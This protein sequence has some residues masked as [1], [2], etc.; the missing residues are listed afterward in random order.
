[1]KKFL[2][3]SG[4]IAAVVAIIAFI[5]LLATNGAILKSGNSQWNYEGTLV[6]FGGER[7]RLFSSR[8]FQASVPGLIGWILVLSA[9]VILLLGVVLPLIKVKA[10]DKFAGLL[11]L[12]AV[13]ALIV[14]G[15]LVFFAAS[16][17]VSAN[18]LSKDTTLGVGWVFAGI[19]AIVAG[20][21]AILPAVFDFVGKKK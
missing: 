11:N 14:G 7:P 5:L 13:I 3:F 6:L 1:M 19:L 9:I 8:H 12:I 18:D 10:L 15:I 17:F 21:L 16:A 4:I 20:V 2:K